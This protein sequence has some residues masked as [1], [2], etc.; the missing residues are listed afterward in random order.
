M[1]QNTHFLTEG[2]GGNAQIDRTLFK[3]GLPLVKKHYLKLLQAKNML[4]YI[5]LVLFQFSTCLSRLLPHIVEVCQSRKNFVPRTANIR[6]KQYL[7]GPHRVNI[8]ICLQ[9]LKI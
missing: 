8:D 6:M 3:K 4:K 2:T 5:E 7:K 1:P 9:I